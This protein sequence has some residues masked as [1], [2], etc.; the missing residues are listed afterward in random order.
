MSDKDLV[1]ADHS[2]TSVLAIIE[3]AALDPSIDVSKMERLLAMHEKMAAVQAER[4]FNVSMNSAQSEMSTVGADAVNPQ[5]RSHYATYD[6]LDRVLRPI[7]TKH[8]FSLSFG[9]GESPKSEHVR[10]ICYVSHTAGH[11]RMYFRDMPADGKGAK[12]GDVMTKTH[13]SG[14]AQSYAMRYLLRAIFNVSVGEE[15]RDGNESVRYLSDAQLDI[16]RKLVDSTGTNLE[17]LLNFI[18]IDSLE[19]VP[20]AQFA[21][22]KGQIER[23]AKNKGA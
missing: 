4:L 17:R 9:E 12:G 10:V 21:W 19:H 22:V 3:R 6:K 5:T 23:R 11:T 2:A 8:G 18:G 16:L 15:D 1:P 20:E 7:Y 14:A 13:A